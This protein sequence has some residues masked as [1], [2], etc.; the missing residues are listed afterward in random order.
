MVQCYEILYFAHAY[1]KDGYSLFVLLY[2][3]FQLELCLCAIWS[4]T[5]G[6]TVQNALSTILI[7][8][9]DYYLS[10]FFH[11]YSFGTYPLVC[12]EQF[13]DG[14]EIVSILTGYN[15]STKNELNSTDWFQFRRNDAKNRIELFKKSMQFAPIE[16][17]CEMIA[18]TI[19]QARASER[20]RKIGML[21]FS[22]RTSL[23][24]LEW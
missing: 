5:H 6:K 9:F 10:P 21:P 13:W 22:N 19:H 7:V 8:H 16:D 15:H 1:K 17:V 12:S 18:A 4:K 11:W 3:I 23:N 14:H 24:K 20:E 2:I